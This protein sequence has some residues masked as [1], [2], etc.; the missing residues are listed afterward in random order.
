MK[1]HNCHIHVSRTLLAVAFVIALILS[2]VAPT[3]AAQEAFIS[4]GASHQGDAQTKTAPTPTPISE[5][6]CI[7]QIMQS[8]LSKARDDAREA[9]IEARTATRNVET[10]MALILQKSDIFS[11]TVAVCA[12]ATAVWSSYLTRQHNKLSVVPRL[13]AAYRFRHAV[14]FYGIRI[15]NSGLGPAWVTSEDL[16]IDGTPVPRSHQGWMDALRTAGL[17]P[18]DWAMTR[19][20]IGTVIRPDE[21]LWIFRAQTMPDSANAIIRC[22]N[23]IELH[24]NYSSLYSEPQPQLRA[25]LASLDML[26]GEDEN[27]QQK[28]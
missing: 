3:I 25:P 4:V 11:L 10:T 15:I 19:I 1:L 24:V 22:F 17:D 18:N 7:N 5:L 8:E 26:I 9:T 13:K 14:N 2:R 28:S 20:L 12:L 23:R 27:W 16:I 21:E 6:T